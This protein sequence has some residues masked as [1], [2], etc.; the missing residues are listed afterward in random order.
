[1]PKPKGGPHQFDLG[2]E[3]FRLAVEACPS[4]MLMI[5]YDGKMVMVNAEIENQ[6]GYSREEL[7]GQSVD[8]LVP[9]RLR[10]RHAHHRRDFAPKPES[11]RMGAGRDLFGRRKDGSEFPVEIGLNPIRAGDQFLVQPHHPLQRG[12]RELLGFGET[13]GGSQTRHVR[14]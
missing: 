4:G 5:D 1:M 13:N 2:G 10:S 14:V 8:M 6:F 11:R 12:T 7:I 3:V 9:E